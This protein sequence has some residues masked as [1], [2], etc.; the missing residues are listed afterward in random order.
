MLE[1]N[2]PEDKSDMQISKIN[3]AFPDALVTNY[4][5]L[6]DHLVLT[7]EKGRHLLAAAIR[8]NAQVIVTNNLKDFPEA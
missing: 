6:I 1:K 8:S 3:K 7:E 2:I 5:Q 4:E